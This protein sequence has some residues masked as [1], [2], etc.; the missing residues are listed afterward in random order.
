[1]PCSSGSLAHGLQ[2]VGL[3]P[4]GRARAAGLDIVAVPAVL[5]EDDRHAGGARRLDQPRAIFSITARRAADVEPGQV[6][7]AAGRG[8]GVL[9]VDHDQ[10][11]LGR[12]ERQGLRARRQGDARRIVGGNV[13]TGLVIQ[14]LSRRHAC[15]AL[16][17]RLDARP[18]GLRRPARS[19]RTPAAR[20]RC[21]ARS[22]TSSSIRATLA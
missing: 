15:P 10:R 19:R 14:R 13:A 21:P 18:E 8:V 17:Q 2:R 22:A 4:V 16:H 6:E 5:E 3:P 7:I 12:I 9:H 1:M 11:R 20:R